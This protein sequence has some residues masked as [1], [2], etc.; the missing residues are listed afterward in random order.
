MILS[1]IMTNSSDE[2]YSILNGKYGLKYSGIELDAMREITNAHTEK[3][4]KDFQK[5]LGKYE[6]GNYF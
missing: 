1:K 4:L 3:S 2:V 5:A 6:N